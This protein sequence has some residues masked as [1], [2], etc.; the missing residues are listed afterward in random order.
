MRHLVTNLCIHLKL[1]HFFLT[2]YHEDRI[3]KEQDLDLESKSDFRIRSGKETSDSRS[4]RSHEKSNI[5]TPIG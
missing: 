2:E 1:F 3:P 4:K 5:V